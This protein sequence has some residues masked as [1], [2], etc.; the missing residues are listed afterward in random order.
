MPSFQ[1]GSVGRALSSYRPGRVCREPDTFQAAPVG[2]EPKPAWAESCCCLPASLKSGA[3]SKAGKR[4]G[5][6]SSKAA[7][8][9]TPGGTL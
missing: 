1:E 7:E 6:S 2:A 4:E 3:K 9:M 8:P 5:S